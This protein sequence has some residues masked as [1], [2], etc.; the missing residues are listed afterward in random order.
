VPFG[1]FKNG[2]FVK[3]AGDASTT[4]NIAHGLGVIPKKVRLV[5]QGNFNSGTQLNQAST[6][7]NGTTQSSTSTYG[8][9]AVSTTTDSSFTLNLAAT[10]GTQVG[11]VTFDATNIIIT[12]TKTNSPTGNY[13]FIWEAE[14]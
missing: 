8:T 12:W 4:Q 3:S 1:L 13:F 9:G 14:A 10:N 5:G 7:Y 11:V 2:D 6:V